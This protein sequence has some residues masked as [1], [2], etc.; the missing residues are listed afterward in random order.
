M[1]MEDKKDRQDWVAVKLDVKNAFNSSSRACLVERVSKIPTLAHLAS[2]FA[3]TTAA[4]TDLVSGGEKSP[5]GN[6]TTDY[7]LPQP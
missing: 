7:I 1:K 5:E 6:V 4:G 3:V 2:L